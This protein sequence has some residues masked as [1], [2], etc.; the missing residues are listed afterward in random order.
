MRTLL[1]AALA[2][3]LAAGCGGDP[4]VPPA[5]G[6]AAR[7]S[8]TGSAD[9]SLTKFQACSRLLADVRRNGGLPDIAALRDIADHVAG[10]RLAADARTA[11]RDLGHTGI[12][13]V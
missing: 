9:V 5:H 12:A 10:P 11:V 8:A 7:P 3:A 2:A 13:P 1:I 4:P 6:D